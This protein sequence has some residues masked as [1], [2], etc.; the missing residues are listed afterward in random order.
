MSVSLSMYTCAMYFWTRINIIGKSSYCVVIPN[1][2][3]H[4][5]VKK[6]KNIMIRRDPTNKIILVQKHVVL[7]NRRKSTTPLC[8]ATLSTALNF[9]V[10]K[11]LSV[12]EFFKKNWII[13]CRDRR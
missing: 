10:Q 9:I 1:H 5:D 2:Q 7:I 8:F 6:K 11:T 4:D 3:H 13:D 12:E